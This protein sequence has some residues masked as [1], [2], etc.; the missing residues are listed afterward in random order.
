MLRVLS[1]H[2]AYDLALALS[3]EPDPRDRGVLMPLAELSLVWAERARRRPVAIATTTSI[4]PDDLRIDIERALD[5]LAPSSAPVAALLERAHRDLDRG[6]ERSLLAREVVERWADEIAWEVQRPIHCI[7]CVDERILH[8]ATADER[9]S[10]ALT[11][12]RIAGHAARI[13]HAEIRI[14]VV[15]S[16]HHGET[17]VASALATDERRRAVRIWLHGITELARGSMTRLADAVHELL[18]EPWPS[19][20]ADDELWQEAVRGLVEEPFEAALN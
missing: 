18:D 3:L 1:R 9:R 10:A 17:C 15:A 13:P 6:P 7:L 14:A 20:P 19:S 2:Q 12:A 5:A 11:V 8:A 4:W 16:A